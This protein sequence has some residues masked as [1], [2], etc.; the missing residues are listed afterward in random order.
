VKAVSCN[1][2]AARDETVIREGRSDECVGARRRLL[3][4]L[5][6]HI[7]I[8]FKNHPLGVKSG[9]SETVCRKNIKPILLVITCGK[10]NE[11]YND[12]F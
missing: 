10:T 8:I 6:Y 4:R 5:I 1:I 9:I 11:A 12:N 2:M 3:Q 7:I